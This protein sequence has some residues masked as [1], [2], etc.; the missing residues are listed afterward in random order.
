MYVQQLIAHARTHDS[1]DAVLLLCQYFHTIDRSLVIEVLSILLEYLSRLPLIRHSAIDKEAGLSEPIAFKILSALT[2][3]RYEIQHIHDVRRLISL[4]YDCIVSWMLF[5]FNYAGDQRQIVLYLLYTFP[6][7]LK[8]DLKLDFVITHDSVELV[9]RLWLSQHE[10]DEFTSSEMLKFFIKHPL[11]APSSSS[12]NLAIKWAQEYLLSD[13]EETARRATQSLQRSLQTKPVNLT[14]MLLLCEIVVILM[15]EYS[16]LQLPMA[17]NGVIHPVTKATL[18]FLDPTDGIND[19]YK[20]SVMFF[21]AKVVLHSNASTR[22]FNTY[23]YDAVRIG[24]LEVLSRFWLTDAISP[25]APR[26]CVPIINYV[27]LYLGIYS[28]LGVVAKA[29]RS[30]KL[31]PGNSERVNMPIR[32]WEEFR[33]IVLSRFIIKY[34]F[35]RWLKQKKSYCDNVSMLLSLN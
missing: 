3:G 21:Y 29:L 2:R 28:F 32:S 4:H 5:L 23:F 31:D 14:V 19:E 11:T 8:L 6:Y 30:L 15:D 1:A 34:N 27:V 35:D 18:L 10:D 7:F 16:P 20:L 25:D 17:R 9:T 13:V 22:W 12:R 33:T 24:M 26:L